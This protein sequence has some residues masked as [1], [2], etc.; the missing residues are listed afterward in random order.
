MPEYQSGSQRLQRLDALR[1]LAMVWMALFHG[2]F[3]LNQAGKFTTI[4]N[5]YLDPFWTLQRTAIVSLFLF[6]AG[7]SQ[8]LAQAPG[9]AQLSRRFWQRWLQITACAAL[10][11]IASAWMFPASWISFG[12]LHGIAV[13]LLVARFSGRLPVAVLLLLGAAIIALPH[14]AQH[15]FF[16]TR[17]TNWIG[18]VTHKP[19]T[20]DYAPLFPWF[21]VM[22]FG[23]CAGRWTLHRQTIL[24]GPLPAVLRPLAPLGR[25]PLTFYMLH[26][27]LLIAGITI[28]VALQSR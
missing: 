2:S 24:S 26:Q 14:F 8:A 21:G 5:F 3:D 22:L 1:G 11:S 17:W 13:M 20:E 10:V 6:C 16:D 27:P 25:W 28:W 23:T 4:Q 7:A 15:A 12:I 18:L 19:I 9:P